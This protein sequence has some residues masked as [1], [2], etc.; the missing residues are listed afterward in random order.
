M[1]INEY[2][3]LPNQKY[4]RTVAFCN[5]LLPG[6]SLPRLSARV[7]AESPL[8]IIGAKMLVSSFRIGWLTDDGERDTLEFACSRLIA[9]NGVG[10]RG[11]EESRLLDR[12]PSLTLGRI[13]DSAA[14]LTRDEDESY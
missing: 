6:M 1:H 12:R 5:D 10:I 2:V 14:R 3:H 9:A 13:G 11:G 4:G 8:S 7:C